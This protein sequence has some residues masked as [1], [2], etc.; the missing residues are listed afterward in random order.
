MAA[1]FII[2]FNQQPVSVSVKTTSYTMPAGKY[3]KVVAYYTAPGSTTAATYTQQSC[4]INGTA[5]LYEPFK[6]VRTTTGS[7]A[8]QFTVPAT[9]SGSFVLNCSIF[10]SSGAS[11]TVEFFWN[12]ALFSRMPLSANQFT[13]SQISGVCSG[14]NNINLTSN[15][16]ATKTL[17]F[18]FIPL[19]EKFETWVPTGTILAGT[20]TYAWYVEEFNMIS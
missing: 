14:N 5:V 13:V 4:T 12:D 10:D 1:P 15:N 11:S 18:S 8:C 2:P 17:G 9:A 20:G 16:S 3:A 19:R 6:C 7:T